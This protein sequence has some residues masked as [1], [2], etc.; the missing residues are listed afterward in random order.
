MG[1][2]S[3]VA[4]GVITLGKIFTRQGLGLLTIKGIILTAFSILLTTV[5]YNLYIRIMNETLTWALSYID[6]KYTEMPNLVFEFT[7]LGAWL[8][9]TIRI[10]DCLS[11]ILTGMSIAW[12]LRLVRV[13]K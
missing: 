5:L 2:I 8:F 1:L 4:T 12:V 13:K 3:S 6:E 7:S 10:D 9:E 11:L